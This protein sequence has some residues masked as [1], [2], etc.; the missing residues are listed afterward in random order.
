MECF[1]T[2]YRSPKGVAMH[3]LI[4][5]SKCLW[6]GFK[7]RDVLCMI[8]VGPGNPRVPLRLSSSNYSDT[9][10]TYETGETSAPNDHFHQLTILMGACD[11]YEEL[12]GSKPL[13]KLCI[14]W[15]YFPNQRLQIQIR[16]VPTK[17]FRA[18]ANPIR[19]PYFS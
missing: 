8:C 13:A 2:D 17:H 14:Q 3:K 11:T 7:D 6:C 5:H 10:L 15:R 19:M 1:G 9:T 16:F 4:L 12:V 18:T